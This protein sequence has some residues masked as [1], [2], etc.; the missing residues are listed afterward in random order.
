MNNKGGRFLSLLNMKYAIF[1]LSFLF[2]ILIIIFIIWDYFEDDIQIRELTEMEL[3]I[4]GAFGG[5][6]ISA[7]EINTGDQEIINIGV[8]VQKYEKGLLVDEVTTKFGN[9]FLPKSSIQFCLFSTEDFQTNTAKFYSL[10]KYDS[11]QSYTQPLNLDMPIR[12]S[13]GIT[14]IRESSTLILNEP[15][16]LA[17]NLSNDNQGTF[18]PEEEVFE[19]EEVFNK[20]IA[21]NEMAMVYRIVLSTE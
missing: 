11:G 10:Y 19:N 6:L 17:I 8:I 13:N 3:A 16:I 14:N 18:I 20:V 1:S 15:I 5:T 4:V 7:H 2:V 12:L 9:N 21:E